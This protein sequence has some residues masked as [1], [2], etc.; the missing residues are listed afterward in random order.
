[1]LQACSSSPTDK[2]ISVIDALQVDWQDDLWTAKGLK[3]MSVTKQKLSRLGNI[4]ITFSVMQVHSLTNWDK[5][6][7]PLMKLL[8]TVQIILHN[9]DI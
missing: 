2:L 6:Y 7:N 3:N 1:M 8:H 4:T 5:V 9:T